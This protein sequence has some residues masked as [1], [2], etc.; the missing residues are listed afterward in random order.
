LYPTIELI[1]VPGPSGPYLVREKN[2]Y[3][4][5]PMYLIAF[6]RKY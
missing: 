3:E 1:A 5:T 4:N 6:D 2:E